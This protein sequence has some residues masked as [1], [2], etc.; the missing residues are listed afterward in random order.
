[1]LDLACEKSLSITNTLFEKRMGK[2][3]SFE[4]PKGNRYL[5]DYILVR[6]KWKNS[7]LNSEA[8][9][10]F[11]SVGS[12]HRVVTARIRLSLRSTKPKSNKNSMTGRS[13]DMIL[14]CNQSLELSS[15]TNTA[16][17]TMRVT[18]SLTNTKHLSRQTS[19]QHRPH[20]QNC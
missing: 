6:S 3:W 4:D 5:L 9:S 11:E 13:L 8:Y 2:R 14:S 17:C 10:S 7:V 20:F 12:D 18:P 1:M 16:C 15:A 19:M